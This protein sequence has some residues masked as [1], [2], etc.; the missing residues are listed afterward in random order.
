[1]KRILLTGMSGTGKSTL[2]RA[3]AAHGYKAIDT[4]TDDW[5]AWVTTPG[6]S[7]GVGTVEERDW[8]WR[9]DR[10]RQLLATEDA[11]I[12][13]VSGCKSNQGAFYPQFD[14]IVLL[15]APT[16]MLLARLATRTTNAYGKHPDELRQ[17]LEHIQTVEPLLRRTASIEIDTS[18]PLAQVIETILGLLPDEARPGE[19]RRAAEP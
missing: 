2:I 7:V 1:M 6:D 5:S 13:F 17:I 19:M 8:V 4:D 16:P 14:H 3:L 18:A 10:L 9:E 15:S 11:P 12:L